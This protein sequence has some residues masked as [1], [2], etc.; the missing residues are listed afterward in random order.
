MSHV[1]GDRDLHEVF[2]FPEANS[3]KEAHFNF[4]SVSPEL[5]PKETVYSNPFGCHSMIQG[6][7]EQDSYKL[8]CESRIREISVPDI[9][10]GSYISVRCSIYADQ[11]LVALK[12]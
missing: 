10:I 6:D 1:A 3:D 5:I 2:L 4:H 12:T 9:K 7:K 8:L 11:Y